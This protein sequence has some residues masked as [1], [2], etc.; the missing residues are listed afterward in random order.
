MVGNTWNGTLELMR[1]IED[2]DQRKTKKQKLKL[3][4]KKQKMIL[5]FISYFACLWCGMKLHIN[6]NL[7]AR[8]QLED[9]G[10]KV[11]CQ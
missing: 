10:P 4:E 2:D 11:N 3:K 8:S 6:L 7:E 5:I 1:T 9:L